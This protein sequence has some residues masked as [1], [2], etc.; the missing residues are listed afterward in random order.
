[1]QQ[2]LEHTWLLHLKKYKKY[3]EAT[4]AEERTC[5]F[6][7]KLDISDEKKL[8]DHSCDID[9]FSAVGFIRSFDFILAC[10]LMIKNN[11]HQYTRY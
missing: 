8:I 11:L 2:Q 4:W 10:S 7:V 9:T 3:R 6:Q 1:M 5:R